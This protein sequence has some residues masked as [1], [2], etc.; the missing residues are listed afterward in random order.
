MKQHIRRRSLLKAGA[1]AGIAS[2]AKTH[3]QT[4]T[5]ASKDRQVVR[6]GV[7]GVGGRGTGLLRTLLT[8]K[9]VEV[10]AVCDVNEA[11]LNLSLIHI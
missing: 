11:N 2:A 4:T 1:A 7:V 10:P 5:K 8:I 9:D 3:A 6:V